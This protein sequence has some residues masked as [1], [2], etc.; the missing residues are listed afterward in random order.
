MHN[1]SYKKGRRPAFSRSFE[2]IKDR[3]RG[4]QFANVVFH[5]YRHLCILG[6]GVVN[7]TFSLQSLHLFQR[8]LRC[9][10][11]AQQYFNVRDYESAKRYVLMYLSAKDDNPIA[12]KLLAQCYEQFSEK[13]KAL[14][15]Y[16]YSLQLDSKQPEL[17]LKGNVF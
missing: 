11:I 14:Q 16:I 6:L 7:A 12:H 13:A 17:I 10:S 5:L 15:E 4:N 3:E 2:E 9:L 1:V 8:N